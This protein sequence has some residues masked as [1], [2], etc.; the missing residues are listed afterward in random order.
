MSSTF[1]PADV[2]NRIIDLM[3]SRNVTQKNLA[4]AINVHKST[5]HSAVFSAEK[6]RN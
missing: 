2:R 3:K 4:L 1:L 5:L 6:Q